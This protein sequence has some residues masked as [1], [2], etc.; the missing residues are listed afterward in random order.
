[1]VKVKKF[2]ERFDIINNDL[3]HSIKEYLLT[4][5]PEFWF[6]NND[7]YDKIKDDIKNKFLLSEQ[8][9]HRNDINE[10]IKNHIKI[11]KKPII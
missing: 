2:Y 9:F 8:E 1:M 10:I 4:N 7:N 5:Y 6:K 11:I 3:K